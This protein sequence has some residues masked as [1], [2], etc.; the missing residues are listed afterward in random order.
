[1]PTFNEV[2]DTLGWIY[3]KKNMTADAVT[4]FRTV[5]QAAPKGPEYHYHYA[6]ALNKQ[7]NRSDATIECQAALDL[8]PKPDLK[9]KNR[10]RS[11]APVK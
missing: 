1:M 2:I 10:S 9:E 7:G 6:M 3:L 4:Q 11:C 8:Q 5:T